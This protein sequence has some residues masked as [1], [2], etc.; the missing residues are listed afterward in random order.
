[1]SWLS[2]TDIV[3]YLTAGAALGAF[4]FVLLLQAVRLYAAQAAAIRIIPLHIMRFAAAVWAFWVIA[5]QGALPLLL[6]LLGFLIAR[7][8]IQRRMGSE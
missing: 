8:A 3:L 2:P 7:I 4:Y 5:Q 1:M 6:S